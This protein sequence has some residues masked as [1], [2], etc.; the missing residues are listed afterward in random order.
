MVITKMLDTK[1]QKTLTMKL[2]FVRNRVIFKVMNSMHE[3]VTF[4]PKRMLGIVD[5][6][7]LGYYKIK[8][9]VLQQNL[10]CMYHFEPVSKVCDQFNRLINTLKR[11][12]EEGT[13]NMDKYP[14]L[15]DSDERK[16]M[17]DKEILDKYID[18]DSSCLT[19]WE[20]QKLRNLIY[21]YK[22]AFSLRDE[23]GMCP[24][25]KVEIDIMDNSP[26]F[27]RPFHA[28]EEDKT[29]LDKEMKRL[30]YLGILKE[31]FS[32]YSSP[33]MLI[34]QKVTQDKRV[35]TDFRHLNMR[36][37]KN[38]LAYPLLKD[39]FMLLGG[40]KCEVLSVLNLKDAFHSLRLT[41]SSKKY[42]GILPYFGSMHHIY[43]KECQWD[44]IFP[45]QC[46][47]HI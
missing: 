29:I 2:K 9:G 46:G 16:H 36:I 30:C 14:W 37:A 3:T 32:A 20:K 1:E 24:N 34:S 23:I 4:D 43:I 28:K 42:C 17:T 41:E 12:E 39:M 33:V 35:V 31:G 13:C 19:K 15:D 45:P 6:R 5:L 11:E 44:L 25:I 26:F 38:N 7:S 40:S 21:D 27:I 47:N 22:D 10:S 18:L 8:Q